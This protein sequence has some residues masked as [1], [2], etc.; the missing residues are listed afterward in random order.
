MEVLVSWAASPTDFV[1]RSALVG[2][3]WEPVFGA[4]ARDPVRG[5]GAGD[6][7]IG[8]DCFVHSLGGLVGPVR[9]ATYDLHLARPAEV[10]GYHP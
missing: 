10:P 8:A 4:W 1:S 5:V 2:A 3:D 7:D 6:A 9:R